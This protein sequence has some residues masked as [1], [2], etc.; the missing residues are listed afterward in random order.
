[1]KLQLTNHIRFGDETEIIQEIHDCEWREKAGYQYLIYQN[2]DKEKVV[3]KYNETELTMSRFSKPQSVMK[4]FAGK[5][6]LIALPTP[7]GIQQFL[8][9]TS[10]Y[11]LNQDSQSLMLHYDLLQAHTETSFASY[12]LELRWFLPITDEN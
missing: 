12:Q 3:I 11:Q 10:H 8:T 1:M 7:M 5:K 9:D 4:F 6:V 2:A